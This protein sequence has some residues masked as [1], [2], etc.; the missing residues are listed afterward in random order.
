MTMLSFFKR[1]WIGVL[2]FASCFAL[3][4]CGTGDKYVWVQSLPPGGGV[5]R[6][7]YA[8]EI[9]DLLDVRVYNEERLS[10]RARVRNDGKISLPLVG[11]LDAQG[12][13][14]SVLSRQIEQALQKF[15]N[16]PSATV[17]V[18]EARPLSVTVVGEVRT[19]GVFNVA[20]NSGVLQ[21]LAVAGG[22]SEFADES[23][24]FV[25]RA[26]PRM[27]IRFTYKALVSHDGRA[28]AFDLQ[29]GDVVTVE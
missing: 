23:A 1:R 18:E 7:E 17:A 29:N 6:T 4:G 15:L 24:I 27:K 26:N 19:P 22:F 9:G 13:T 3:S 11:E 2:G 28:A 21:A 12:K 10:V 5:P 16:S 25:V 8:I 14:P 20:P